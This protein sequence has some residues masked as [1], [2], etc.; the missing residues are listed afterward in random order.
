[1]KRITMG[2][3]WFVAIYI[4]LNILVAALAGAMAGVKN[5]PDAQALGITAAATAVVQYGLY[6]ILIS[7]FSALAGTLSR[8]L[9]GTKQRTA[10]AANHQWRPAPSPWGFWATLGFSGI[11]AAVFVG[12]G[13]ALA[14]PFTNAQLA[15][16]PALD[17][18]ASMRSLEANGLYMAVVTLAT[19]LVCSSL[20]MLFA[21]LR[22]G[23]TIVD[24]LRLK[25]VPAVIL[26]RWI[27]TVVLLA[28]L[29]DVSNWLLNRDLV[30]QVLVQAYRTAG[31]IPLFWLA[32]V[33][34]APVFEELFFRGFLFAGLS[35][36][37]LGPK[38]AIA[39]TAV[40]WGAIHV[41]YEIYDILLICVA[42]VILGLARVKTGS[43][44]VPL[45]MHS[46][47]NLIATVETWLVT[48]AGG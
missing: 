5:P 28:V 32:I 1:V 16:N 14:V 34:A 15:G 37:F 43:I 20:I 10:A 35:A 45:L 42:G 27:L 48:R 9:P 33:V 23:I 26:S 31:I 47:I 8:V 29:W 7:L 2:F 44:Y 22:N 36:S 41:Q 40:I 24:Y 13:I 19:S 6:I 38:G 12:L 3:L 25:S 30:P 11:I 39:L 21:G 4:A 46:T 18:D 17:Y